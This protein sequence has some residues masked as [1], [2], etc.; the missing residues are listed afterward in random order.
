MD[1]HGIYVPL[2]TP[3]T[4]G[5][6]LAAGALERLAHEVLDEGAAGLVALGTTAEA[7]TL[8]DAERRTVVELC[9]R[10]CR[11]RGATLIVGAG[12][13][14]TRRSAEA[15]AK[16]AGADAAL[17]AVPAF[18]RPGEE[19]VLAHFAYLAERSPVPLIVYHIP[20]RT[21]Q[22]L[23]AAA[24]RRL[25]GLPGVAGVKLAVGGVDQAAMELLGDVPPGFAVLAG[26]D[27]YL[28]PLL[29]LGA[30][31]GILAAAHLATGRFVELA[32][33]WGK[34]DAE[35]ARALGHRLAAMAGAAFAEPNPTVIKGVLHAQGRIPS[36]AVRLPLL[37]AGRAS[38]DHA[39]E[40]LAAL[41]C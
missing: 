32:E 38:V 26:D 2:V 20:Y 22:T 10:V 39:L 15:L 7:A 16:L 30:A 29:A 1:L 3:F 25:G 5:G 12:S 11:E 17:V 13:S 18:S 34:G 8:D 35:H 21:G 9:A 27:L 40:R 24:L 14:D 23:S 6:E 28:S 4:D 41:A 19:G 37:P 36:P 33:A 31:G